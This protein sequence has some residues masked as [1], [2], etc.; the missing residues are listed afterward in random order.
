MVEGL[1]GGKRRRWKVVEGLA[2]GVWDAHGQKARP[3]VPPAHPW[4]GRAP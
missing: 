3:P 1:P 4:V 2:V